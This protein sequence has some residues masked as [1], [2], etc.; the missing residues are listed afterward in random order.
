MNI[1]HLEKFLQSKIFPDLRKGD[2]NRDLPHTISIVEKVKE[3]IQNTHELNLKLSILIIAAYCH[4]WGYAPFFKDD[5]ESMSFEE[6]A[7]AKK[8]HM[9]I[10]AEMTRD[11]LK[12]EYFS[13]LSDEEKERI[14]HLVRVHD[15]VEELTET[16]EL[17]LMEADTLA[18]LDTDFIK[19][20]FTKEGND[21]YIK[22]GVKRNRLPRF[23]TEHGKRM[24]E[25]YLRKREE[26]YEEHK[27]LLG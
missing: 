25:V 20:T 14:V 7:E 24:V 18:G 5:G 3:I 17:V 19:P 23:I 1:Q 16:D 11:L 21:K 2:L 8:H 10:G 4:D 22:I 27:E 13:F 12:D 15:N 9:E 6:Y 26:Y